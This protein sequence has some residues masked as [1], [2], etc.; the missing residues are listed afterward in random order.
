MPTDEENQ[1][2]CLQYWQNA[3]QSVISLK[4]LRP[5][6][7]LPMRC[8]VE[9]PEQLMDVLD[10]IAFAVVVELGPYALCA[11]VFDARHP[12]GQFLVGVIVPV[13]LRCAVKTDV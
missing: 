9:L 2:A 10:G 1:Q 5:I 8:T 11:P 12:S 4:S 7:L 6:V 3:S 13:L